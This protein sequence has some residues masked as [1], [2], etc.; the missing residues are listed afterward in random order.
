MIELR[1]IHDPDERVSVPMILDEI[2][3]ADQARA[4]LSAVYDDPTITELRVFD[5]GDGEAMSGILV[6]GRRG[7]SGDATFPCSC[8]I[9]P[10]PP[11]TGR[12]TATSKGPPSGIR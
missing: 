7:A 9:D 2:E 5:L 12:G 10:I 8:S 6:V 11:N 1:A 3:G 4:A